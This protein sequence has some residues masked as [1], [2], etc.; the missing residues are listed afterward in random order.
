MI[1]F[2][3]RRDDGQ[4]FD[5]HH[6]QIPRMLRPSNFEFTAV[7][8]WGT[9]RIRIGNIDISFSDEDPGF[10][11]CFESE[12]VDRETAAKIV[13]AVAANITSVTGQSH[14]IVVL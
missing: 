2:L 3:I 1:E 6:D 12:D 4:W 14:R 11:V 13:S 9:H 5:F 10:Q 8:G 7:D